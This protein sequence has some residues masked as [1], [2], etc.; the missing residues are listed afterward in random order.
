MAE[1]GKLISRPKVKIKV[2]GVGGGGNSVLM[3]MAQDNKL[4][5]ELIAVNTDARQLQQVAQVD[6]SIMTVQLGAPLTRGRG[7]GGNVELAQHAA[8]Q[9]EAKLREA[10]NGAD[11]VFITAGLG[12]GTGTGVAPVL[13]RM[14]HDAHILSAG[15]V[16]L[17]FS[18]EGARKM[19]I[20]EQGLTQMQLTMDALI[21]VKN[22][23]IMRLPE[24][25]HMSLVTALEAVTRERKGGV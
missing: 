2:F 1:E 22:D 25:L 11:L 7:T 6:E 12:G 18:F 13:A 23:N 15:V 9:D 4:D 21:T 16:T 3:R 17:P 14:A 20:A 19:R 5:L 24:N 10:M 8:A